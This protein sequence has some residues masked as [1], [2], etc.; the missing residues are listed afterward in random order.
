[1]PRF[2]ARGIR[3]IETPVREVVSDSAGTLVGVRLADETLVSRRVLVVATR[4][5]ARTEGIEGL[6]LPMED[7]AD[8]MGRRFASGL[9]GVTEVPG[10]WVA[11]NATDPA[12]QVGA[13]AAAGA[14]AGA[15]INSVLVTADTDAAVAATK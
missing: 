10:I 4:M 3:V 5:R 6:K 12:A 7:L 1:M 9:A 14:L 15:H 8:D 2:A 13:S 11:G